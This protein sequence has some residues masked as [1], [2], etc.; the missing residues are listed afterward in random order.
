MSF[1]R[2]VS[3][4]VLAWGAVL[5]LA[6]CGGSQPEQAAEGLEF[7]ANLLTGAT[8]VPT[9][10]GDYYAGYLVRC[11]INFVPRRVFIALELPKYEKGERLRVEG[12]FAE[13]SVRVSYENRV[14]TNI[15][16]FI[17][18]SAKI[19]MGEKGMPPLLDIL[20]PKR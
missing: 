14:D 3:G 10:L 20:S 18:R 15:P 19:D 12:S 4:A 13:D 8:Y 17:V 1:R 9:R 5:A 6:C 11:E 2:R 16:L 7:A